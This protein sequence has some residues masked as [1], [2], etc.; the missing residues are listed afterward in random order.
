M[1]DNLWAVVTLNGEKV[2]I[3]PSNASKKDAEK[4]YENDPGEFFRIIAN[5]N[6]L[7][8]QSTAD[9]ADRIYAVSISDYSG[10][11]LLADKKIYFINN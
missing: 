8:P 11:A 7:L 10:L 5:K 4:F 1:N 6:L 3:I 9:S 2:L